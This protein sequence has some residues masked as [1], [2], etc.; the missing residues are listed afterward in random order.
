M[1]TKKKKDSHTFPCLQFL[2]THEPSLG[3]VQNTSSPEYALSFELLSL[4]L[5][6]AVSILLFTGKWL[7]LPGSLNG[8]CL[9]RNTLINLI[10]YLKSSTR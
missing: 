3:K 10:L 4:S 2:T 6:S 9:P 7:Y 1:Y 5:T 8:Y